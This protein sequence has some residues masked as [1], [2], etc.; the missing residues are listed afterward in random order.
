MKRHVCVTAWIYV[1][2]TAVAVA[3]MAADQIPSTAGFEPEAVTTLGLQG[4]F[5]ALILAE[6]SRWRDLGSQSLRLLDSALDDLRSGRMTVRHEHVDIDGHQV[7]RRR[8]T[9]RKEA[10]P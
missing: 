1:L 10:E 2:T 7:E 5:G 4:V 3:A 8:P 6:A 9:R